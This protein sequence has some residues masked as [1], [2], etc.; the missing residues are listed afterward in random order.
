MG[1]TIEIGPHRFKKNIDWLLNACGQSKGEMCQKALDSRVS[2]E[3]GRRRICRL[4]GG[5][6]DLKICDVEAIA[7]IFCIPPA[8]LVYG[9][10]EQIEKSWRNGHEERERRKRIDDFRKHW[11]QIRV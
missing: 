9:T 2:K 5:Y 6:V 11:N 10:A 4:Q 7:A 8:V 3:S 1:N